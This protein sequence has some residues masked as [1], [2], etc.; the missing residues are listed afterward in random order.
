YP[1]ENRGLAERI[2]SSGVGALISELALGKKSFRNAFV[3]RDRIQSGMSL[4]VVPVQTDLTGGTMHTVRFAELQKRLL[5]CPKP[6]VTEQGL[7][8]Y[9]GV[10]DLIQTRRARD[11]QADDYPS[12]L[13]LL[14]EQR[15]ELLTTDDDRE[16]VLSLPEQVGITQ[17]SQISASQL[18]F[19]A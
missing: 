14:E 1:A 16:P 4:A 18:D 8:Q 2:S 6:L 12:L 19:I 9:A 5:L 7:K 17:A 13:T 15:Q 11:F 10:I 3:Q